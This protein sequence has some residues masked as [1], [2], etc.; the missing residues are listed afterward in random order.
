MTDDKGSTDGPQSVPEQTGAPESPPTVRVEPNSRIETR[1][2][3]LRKGTD[4]AEARMCAKFGRRDFRV[5]LNSE[6]LWSR[7]YAFDDTQHFDDDAAAK[8]AEFLALG[9]EAPGEA[10]GDAPKGE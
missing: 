9:W 6:L 4:R 7:N 5:Y 2:W 3:L 10:P 1:L 8:Y